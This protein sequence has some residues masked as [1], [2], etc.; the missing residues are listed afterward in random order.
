MPGSRDPEGPDDAELL[1]RAAAGDA[2]A[3]G[4]I[5]ER[6]QHLVYRFA[7]AMTGSRDAAEDVTQE[8]FIVLIRDLRRYAPERAAL[9]SYLYGIARNVSRDRLRRERR[10][11]AR[12]AGRP[13]ADDRCSRDPFEQMASVETGADV[14]HA[15]ARIPVRYR[16]VVILCDLHDLSY[17][18]VGAILHASVPAVRSRL[19]RGRYLLRQR[20]SRAPDATVRRIARSSARCMG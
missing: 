8:V 13:P 16:E 9:G 14:R 1:H 20:L 6:Y 15:L 12:L 7:R 3:F 10:F 11:L 4:V 19:H 17:A 18:E 2:D 5:F